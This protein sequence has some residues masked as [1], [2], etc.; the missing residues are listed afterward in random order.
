MK[1][2]EKAPGHLLGVIILI[3]CVAMA[4]YHLLSTQYL[5]VDP[6]RHQNI[7]LAFSL[8]LIF[9]PLLRGSNASIF[10]GILFLTLSLISVAYVHVNHEAL[11]LTLGFP[12]PTDVVVGVVL[13]FLALESTR[14]AWGI[15]LPALAM[16]AIIYSLVADKLPEPFHGMDFPLDG[17]IYNLSIGLTGMYGMVLGI[18]ANFIFLFVLFGALLEASG[19]TAF[20]MEVGKIVG[21]RLQ[22]GPAIS[23]VVTSALVGM[24]TGSVTANIATTG[25][26]TIPM[27][28]RVGYRPHQAAAIEASASTG[29]QMM[30]PI[31]GAAA[32][33]M[34]GF[35]EIPYAKIM[36]AAIIPSILYFFSIAAYAQLNA[37]KLG[38]RP[39]MET[40]D[41]REML[42][43]APLFILPLLIL[44]YLLIA[45]FTAMFSIFWAT[46][47]L[48][49]CSL[50]LS[51]YRF[52]R[53]ES[54]ASLSAWARSFM[55]KW[56]TGI[57]KGAITGAQVAV[58][59]AAIGIVVYVIDMTG[60]GVKLPSAVE[61]ASGG[62]LWVALI[63]TM[64]VSLILGCGM[65]TGSVYILVAMVTAPVLVGM[66]IELMAAHFF[67]FYF[68]C[69][70]FV[71]PPIGIGSLVAA[72][73]A[74]ASYLKTSIE[75]IKTSVAGFIL[76]FLFIFSP[77]LLLQSHDPG[78]II[79]ET[80]LVAVMLTVLQVAIC[81]R[82]LVRLN[83][84]SKFLFFGVAG[85]LFGRF[86]WKQN[87]LLL[88]GFAL[89]LGLT[90]WQLHLRK[91]AEGN[92][93][94]K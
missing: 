11:K 34:S 40:V 61:A 27:M 66:G 23:G 52:A 45:G 31:M 91:K 14:R 26:F 33:L 28:K 68:G 57:E 16:V 60:L 38:M 12:T 42:L 46:M 20:F 1:D 29:G 58:S 2:N 17:V 88:A 64:I 30:P 59:C 15:L 76:P 6:I 85:L 35:T 32:F 82:Y 78:K 7:H 73:L 25:A 8:C 72:R 77:A 93:R 50:A 70:S 56:L 22:G 69:I 75:A 65:P 51:I 19:A 48:I 10:Q 74:N 71:T 62:H 87:T 79:F 5:L 55:G 81:G 24:V 80:F 43:G 63:L 21:R 18:S 41:L 90:A 3:I 49:A 54:E 67:V 4:A 44:I 13:I 39:A 37:V 83:S 36:V 47:T 53:G 84:L 89:L 9:L 92:S 94:Q 86:I